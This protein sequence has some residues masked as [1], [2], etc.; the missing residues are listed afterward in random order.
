[1]AWLAT[2]LWNHGPYMWRQIRGESKPYPELN[3]QEMA[4]ILPFLDQARSIDRPGDAR[5]PGGIQ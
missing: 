3:S 1:M 4:D 5:R 2:A